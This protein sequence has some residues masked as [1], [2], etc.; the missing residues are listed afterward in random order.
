VRSV[1]VKF[2]VLLLACAIAAA[3]P[4]PDIHAVAHVV[5]ERYNRLHTLTAD[6]TEIYRGAGMERTETGVLWLKK[7]GK[8]RWEYRSPREKLFLSDSKDAGFYVQGERQVR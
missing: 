4:A 7:P 6:F 3:Q 5:D 8:M 1:L 2:A